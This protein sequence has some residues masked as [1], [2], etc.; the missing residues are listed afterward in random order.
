[1]SRLRYDN[2]VSNAANSRLDSR[3]QAYLKEYEML[4]AENR[5]WLT[6]NDPKLATGF[7]ACVAL[8]TAGFW[9]DKYPLFL[10]I[11]LV[12]IFLGLILLFQLENLIHLAAQLVVLEEKINEL[13]GPEPVM[14]YF[15]KTVTAIMDRPTYRDPVTHRRHLS[16][17]IIYGTIGGFILTLGSVFSVVFGLPPLYRANPRLAWIYCA[18]LGVG[19]LLLLL[20]LVRSFTLKVSCLNLVRAGYRIKP[21]TPDTARVSPN[22]VNAA[23]LPTT[24][25]EQRQ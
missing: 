17:N 11:P 12:T 21:P 20:L 13:L 6:S 22:E 10:L 2:A 23:G 16:P 7:A 19:V 8:A 24:V 18:A 5:I 4:V 9:R 1:M 3:L 25:D 15:S 14:T